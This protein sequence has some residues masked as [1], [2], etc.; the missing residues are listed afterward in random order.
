MW[1]YSAQFVATNK[2]QDAGAVASILAAEIYGL[3][4]LDQD[5]QVI[6]FVSH[7]FVSYI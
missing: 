6:M 7:W 3:N 4:I 5:I 1:T 2:L